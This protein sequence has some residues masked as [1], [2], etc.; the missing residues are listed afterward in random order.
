MSAWASYR[1]NSWLSSSIRPSFSTIGEIRGQDDDIM[2]PVQTAHPAF[3][4]GEKVNLALGINMIG[5]SGFLKNQRV[6]LEYGVPV[7]QNLNGPQMKTTSVLILGWQ[8]A[9]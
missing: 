9:F 6:A 5:Q 4:G 3:Q 1:I 8:Y 2:L 7:Y